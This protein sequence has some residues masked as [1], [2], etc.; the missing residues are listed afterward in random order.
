MALMAMAASGCSR[1]AVVG[2]DDGLSGDEAANASYRGIAE[3]PITLHDGRWE[4]QPFQ[5]GG[6][7]RPRAGLLE[8]LILHGDLDGDGRPET[9]AFLWADGG[10]SGTQLY[11]AVL[12][13]QSGRVVNLAS[14]GIGDRVQIRAARIEDR[15]IRLDLIQSGPEDAACCPGE[16]A[17]RVWKLVSESGDTT[18]QE[19]PPR[20][21]G[22][23]SLADLEGIDWQLDETGAMD[24]EAPPITLRVEGQRIGG[25]SGCNRYSA[26]IHSGNRPGDMTIGPVMGTRMACPPEAMAREDR[27]LKQLAGV[28]RFGFRAGNLLLTVRGDDGSIDSL[29]LSAH[30]PP[31]EPDHARRR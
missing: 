6:A 21:D 25:H 17:L 16:K 19:L 10:G 31:E 27:Y 11:L 12:A 29:T 3:A 1:S 14:A 5:P 2:T 4:G 30:D 13:R 18:L 20:I 9:V 8:P 22:R 7:S 23:L 24:T 28:I 15:R 26:G